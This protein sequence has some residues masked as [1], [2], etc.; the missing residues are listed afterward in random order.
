MKETSVKMIKVDRVFK[1]K[2]FDF[3]SL[4]Q[5][6]PG[7]STNPEPLPSKQLDTLEKEINRACESLNQFITDLNRP[8]ALKEKEMIT[9]IEDNGCTIEISDYFKV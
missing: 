8:V 9:D 6:F 5:R 4:V 3:R 2:P 1:R 7:H